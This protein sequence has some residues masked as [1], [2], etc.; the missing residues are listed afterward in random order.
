MLTYSLTPFS[1]QAPFLWE[2]ATDE[3]YKSINEWNGKL[4]EI[5]VEAKSITEGQE[6]FE[7]AV[8]SWKELKT[9]RRLYSVSS[10]S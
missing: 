3:A 2:V 9:C 7:L 1:A 5:E 8:N 6:L 10:V 4:C